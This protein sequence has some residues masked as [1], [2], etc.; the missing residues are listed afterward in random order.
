VIAASIRAAGRGPSRGAPAPR[1]PGG[2]ER[3]VPCPR[4]RMVRR[5]SRVPAGRDVPEITRGQ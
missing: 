1:R 4:G 2:R 3:P 5:D